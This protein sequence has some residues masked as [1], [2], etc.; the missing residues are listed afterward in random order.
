VRITMPSDQAAMEFEAKVKKV[1]KTDNF[2]AHIT[3]KRDGSIIS[4][5]LEFKRVA[6]TIRVMVYVS[7]QLQNKNSS[8]DF[9]CSLWTRL[10]SNGY[11]VPEAPWDSVEFLLIKDMLIRHQCIVLG[12]KN[13]WRLNA[14]LVRL[15]K[16]A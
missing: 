6:L 15:I 14:N 1:L 13:S 12:N 10:H 11:I 5:P 4:I 3:N 2:V 7:T 16:E 8:L 9:Y